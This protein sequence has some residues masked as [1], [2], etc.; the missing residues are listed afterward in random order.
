M[1]IGT[2]EAIKELLD[3]GLTPKIVPDPEKPNVNHFFIENEIVWGKLFSSLEMG[4]DKE[5]V[6][7]NT[8]ISHK[9]WVK[10]LIIAHN[11]KL[12]MIEIEKKL[13][14]VV[15]YP[16]MQERS[17]KVPR[18][19]ENVRR[20]MYLIQCYVSDLLERFEF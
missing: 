12:D 9:N 10:R 15:V 20:W 6:D 13:A 3:R 19:E 2:Q 18:L 16:Q 4:L 11:P 5:G 8:F 7:I 17:S 1:T 14:L